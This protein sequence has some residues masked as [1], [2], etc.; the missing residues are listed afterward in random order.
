FSRPCRDSK[1]NSHHLPALKCWAT[2][3]RPS[4]TK[5][6]AWPLGAR[7][8][9]S[10]NFGRLRNDPMKRFTIPALAIACILGLSITHQAIE[11]ARSQDKI[12]VPSKRNPIALEN[13]KKGST[14]WQLTRVKLDKGM[15]SFRTS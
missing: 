14:D 10:I 7:Y 5:T 15:A 12:T 3:S 13:A 2:F 6:V 8:R 11:P 9:A 4:G 1:L